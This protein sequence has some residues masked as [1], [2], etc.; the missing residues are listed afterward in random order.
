MTAKEYLT[1]L[2]DMDRQIDLDLRELEQWR[3]LST[4]LTGGASEERRSPNRATEA[5]FV[6]CVEKI[7]ELE[8]KITEEVDAL[9]DFKAEALD[10][11]RR[12][13]DFDQREVLEMRY[14]GGA[15]W[16][17]IAE[18][19]HFTTRWILRL[20]SRGLAAL[21]KILREQKSAASVH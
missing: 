11:I 17:D 6:K 15:A 18:K 20:H 7:A 10:M 21:E 1:R 19:R 13:P 5:P 14:L 3:A 4:R 16:S 2:K 12:I 8:R 9:V